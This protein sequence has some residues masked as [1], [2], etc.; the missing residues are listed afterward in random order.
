MDYYRLI[1][2]TTSAAAEVLAAALSHISPFCEI[3]DP[4]NVRELTQAPSPR[5]DY[6]GEELFENSGRTPT[7]T[8]YFERGEQGALLLREAEAAV[9]A[10]AQNDSQGFY[11]SLKMRVDEVKSEDWENNWKQYYKP[12]A[13][14]SRLL[15]RPSWEP[16]PQDAQ[17]RKVLT[18]DPSSSFGTGSHATTRLCMETLDGMELCGANVLDMGC[19]SG[20]LA[21][22]AVL[23][24]AQSAFLCD[25]EPAAVKTAAENVGQAAAEAGT[26]AVCRAA[27]GNWLE[28]AGLAAQIA[29]QGPYDVI[30]ANIVADV[31]IAMCTGLISVLRPGGVI[32]LSGIIDSRRDEVL[33]TYEKAGLHLECEKNRDGWTMFSMKR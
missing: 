15:V 28:N 32:L 13:V 14:G 24:G 9:R 25:I 2:E 17:G 30:C 27:C 8:F 16:V 20:I 21:A 1:I 19:G 29:G 7:V 10:L 31:L 33:E 11:G 5:W 4:D 6:L 18:I 3:D 12:F 22:T 23:L 26:G